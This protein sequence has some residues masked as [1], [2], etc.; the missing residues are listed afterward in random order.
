MLVVTTQGV[1]SG[2]I[3]TIIVIRVRII[4]VVIAFG[5]IRVIVATINVVIR[6][7]IST[8]L[9]RMILR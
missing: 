3:A 5:I 7:P 4:M 9:S 6:I 2:I 8:T 1:V